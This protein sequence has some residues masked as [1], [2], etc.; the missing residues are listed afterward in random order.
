MK[1]V[2]SW[3][4]SAG[5]T[6]GVGPVPDYPAGRGTPQEGGGETDEMKTSSKSCFLGAGG[7]AGVGPCSELASRG[8][9]ETP[10]VR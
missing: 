3:L 2:E 5:G 7:T 8:G 1:P 6:A 9:E 4:S 10:Q